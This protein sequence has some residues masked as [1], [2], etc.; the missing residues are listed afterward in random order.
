MKDF[1]TLCLLFKK[2]L[3][4]NSKT[5]DRTDKRRIRKHPNLLNSSS[6]KISR[7]IKA[8][9]KK[10]LKFCIAHKEGCVGV[11]FGKGK[12]GLDIEEMK[13][14]NF[15]A[16]SEFCFTKNEVEEYGKSKSKEKFYQIYTCKEALLKAKNLSFSELG[17][18]DSLDDEKYIKKSFIINDLF[19]ISIVFK[20]K[21]D[22]IC[23]FL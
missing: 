14:R 4:F 10:R 5:L 17:I 16:I 1:L 20:G 19:M 12:F 8:K 22:I 9:F 6:F 2:D 13:D 23:K 21:K 15:N 11:L 7:A 3:R 18:V